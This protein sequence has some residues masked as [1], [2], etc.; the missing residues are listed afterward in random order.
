M[1]K[2]ICFRFPFNWKN[3]MGYIIAVA[4][5][6]SMASE[7][8]RYMAF[9]LTL[10]IGGFLWSLS[11]AEDIK[12]DANTLNECVRTKR[13]KSDIFQRFYEIIRCHII[14]IQLRVC[15]N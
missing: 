2:P 5:Q 13:A 6:I 12:N 3:P 11:L 9:A 14:A 4:F 10:P 7:A 1:S 15:K 8:L